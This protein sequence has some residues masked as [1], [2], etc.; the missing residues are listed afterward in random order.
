MKKESSVRTY[1]GVIVVVLM[2]AGAAS[3]QIPTSGN[4]FIG[5]SYSRENAALGGPPTVNRDGW[6]GSLEGKFLP[7]IGLVADFGAGYGSITELIAGPGTSHVKIRKYTYLFGP[8]VS[9]PIGRVTPFAH[10]LVGAGH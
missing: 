1:A 7:W 6:E 9:V 4:I 5:Y 10:A 8:R 2:I 3:A